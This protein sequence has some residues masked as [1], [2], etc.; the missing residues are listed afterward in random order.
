[1]SCRPDIFI[2][3][4]THVNKDFFLNMNR[5]GP[6]ID[7]TLYPVS[8]GLDIRLRPDTEYDILSN[9]GYLVGF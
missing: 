8:G 5:D 7:L 6:D 2:L 4:L 3:R 1:M 9:T